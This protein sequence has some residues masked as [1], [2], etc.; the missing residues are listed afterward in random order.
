MLLEGQ[1]LWVFENRLMKGKFK[2]KREDVMGQWRQLR[3][4]ELS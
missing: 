2:R 4:G 1:T 3:N